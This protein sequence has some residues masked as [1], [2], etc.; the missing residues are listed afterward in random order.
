MADLKLPGDG[1]LGILSSTGPLIPKRGSKD[2]SA[3]AELDAVN[4]SRDFPKTSAKM[5]ALHD[6]YDALPVEPNR[7]VPDEDD[8]GKAPF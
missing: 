8:D 2:L 7:P 3:K 4:R 6:K 1:T 5:R